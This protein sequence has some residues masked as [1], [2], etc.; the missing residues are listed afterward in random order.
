MPIAVHAGREQD[1]GIDHAPTFADFHRQRVGGD[2][3]EG[4][5]LVQGAVAELFDVLVQRRRHPAD[6]R[7]REA[8]DA[9]GLDELVHAAGGD[10]GEVAVRDDCDQSRFGAFAP[11]EQPLGEVGAGAELGDGD[12]DRADAGVEVAVT[13]AVALSGPVRAGSAVL[14][15][16]NSVRVRG[17]QGVDHVLQ[18]AAHQI[19][20]R[21]GQGFTEQAVRVDNMGSGHR[22]D[23]VRG[24]CGRLTRRITR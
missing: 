2:E 15:A 20:G 19:R 4:A 6:L 16:D 12:V 7:L 17:Q 9:E 3:G 24:F 14:G 13:V 23:S 8:V 10:T 1:D 18:Q 21:F 11:L 22:D 5:G